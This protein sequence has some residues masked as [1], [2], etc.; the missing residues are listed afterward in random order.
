MRKE[1]TWAWAA[2][3]W[4]STG[5]LVPPVTTAAFIDVGV[6]YLNVSS[7][8]ER[9]WWPGSRGLSNTRHH[10]DMKI[11]WRFNFGRDPIELAGL[12]EGDILPP[13]DR[14]DALDQKEAQEKNA[15]IDRV[16]LWPGGVVYYEF[17]IEF[18]LLPL[19][20]RLIR[21]V[22]EDIASHSCIHFRE[23][24]SEPD[25]IKIIF[26]RHRCYSHIGRV[27]GEQ[28]V[29]L[30]IFCV[31]WWNLGTVYHELF[32]TLGFYHE[33]T[34]PDRDNYVEVL[35]DNIAKGQ[36]D[37]FLKR[38]YNSVDL[39]D[40]PYDLD[41][42]MHYSP[43][44][45]G[46]WSFLTP[47]IRSRRRG[48][49]FMR[50]GEPSKVDY[51]KLNRLYRCNR[52]GRYVYSRLS[53]TGDAPYHESFRRSDS[54][55]YTFAHNHIPTSIPLPEKILKQKMPVKLEL[56]RTIIPKDPQHKSIIRKPVVHQ[57]GTSNTMVSQFGTSN[58]MV[59][60][61]GTSN[62]MVPQ[63]GTSNTMVP[64]FATSKP[65]VPQTSKQKSQKWIRTQSPFD[66]KTKVLRRAKLLF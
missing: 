11:K 63:F 9:R 13:P 19:E 46:K 55:P 61:F 12:P 37:N 64:Q 17:S 42:V 43:F 6:P 41:S 1:W 58:T 60:Q 52:I 23:R 31:N 28:L 40:M 39:T 65:V 15:V 3:V 56:P 30:G 2:V 27:G 57:F 22:M 45:F 8:A 14:S 26:D 49:Y 38:S 51:M 53:N 7:S 44:A 54:G 59:P 50:A 34:R 24:T 4:A 10:R 29:S 25:F 36:V 20:R 5:L 47:T 66:I 62:T 33:H 21:Q 16:R 48:Y 18:M 32:H 35:W